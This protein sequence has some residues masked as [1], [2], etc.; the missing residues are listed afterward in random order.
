MNDDAVARERG[1]HRRGK[2]FVFRNE[3]FSLRKHDRLAPEPAHRLREREPIRIGA[4]DDKTPGRMFQR[5]ERGAVERPHEVEPRNGQDSLDG[6]GRD[7]EASRLDFLAARL[8]GIGTGEASRRTNDLYIHGFE[9]RLRII[10]RD[11]RKRGGGML[12]H[13]REIDLRLL[14]R[15][16][17][18]RRRHA[19]K[20]RPG[21]LPARRG[22]EWHR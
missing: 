19:P 3:Y 22:A 14:V 5:A 15:R 2:F 10:W 13:A 16:C 11:R 4:D 12:T 20:W 18:K 21:S 7:N 17:R 9:T 6:S 8:A 1:A